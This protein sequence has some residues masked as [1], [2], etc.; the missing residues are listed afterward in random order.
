MNVCLAP[1]V[2][3]TNACKLKGY[4]RSGRSPKFG[5]SAISLVCV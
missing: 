4:L 5:G 2:F 3:N 1:H